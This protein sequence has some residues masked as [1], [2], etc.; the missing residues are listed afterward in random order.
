MLMDINEKRLEYAIKGI[1]KIVDAG[2]YPAIV[3]G[4]LNRR[5]ALKDADGVPNYHLTRWC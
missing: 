4:T 5:E 3:K 1:Q 2:N